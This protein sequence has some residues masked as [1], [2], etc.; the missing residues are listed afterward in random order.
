I[1]EE[2]FITIKTFTFPADVPIVQ[3][4]MEMR[5]IEV[6]MKNLTASRL[7]YSIGDI[8]MQVKASDYEV[9]KNALIEG[10]FAEPE[11]FVL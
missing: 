1:M 10:G 8:E 3:T 5:G 4:F 7:A 9:A 2:E 11:D 6:F